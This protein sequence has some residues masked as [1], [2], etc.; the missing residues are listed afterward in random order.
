MTTTTE[1][2]RYTK[3]G[4]LVSVWGSLTR[5]DTNS[6]SGNLN[7]RNFP[8]TVQAVSNLTRMG[9]GFIWMDNGTNLDRIGNVYMD[10]SSIIYGV[11]DFSVR[12][13]RYLQ[14]TSM[15][16]GRPLYF[17]FSYQTGQ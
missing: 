7:I 8:F 13:G 10:G 14:I 11:V 16:N 15:T 2:G 17:S 3:I 1:V 6:T 12:T 9:M 4:N 5:N